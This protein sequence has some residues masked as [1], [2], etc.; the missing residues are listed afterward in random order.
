M[1]TSGATESNN[2]VLLGLASYGRRIGRTHILASSIEHTSVL[3]PL[4]VLG[5]ESFDIE[6]LPVGLDGYV[7]PAEVRSRLRSDTLLVSIMHANNETGVLQPVLEI[8]PLVADSKAFF[9]VDAAQTFG[10]EVQ[11]LRALE[12][13]FLSISGH[14]ILGPKGV[15]ALFVKRV[16][17]KRAML[18]PILHGGGQEWGLRPGTLPVPLIVG[19]GVAAELA[20]GEHIERAKQAVE[21]RR[22]FEC[23]LATVDHVVNGDVKRMQSHVLNVS[24]PGVD[25]EALMLALRESMAISNGAA[26]SSA[27]YRQSHVLTAMGFGPDRISSSVRFS[28]GPGVDSIPFDRLVDAIRSLSGPTV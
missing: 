25:S 22:E 16:G 21:I 7:H 23:H 15:G 27:S 19:L 4:E 9:H 14:K 11:E 5:R 12:C 17:N 20:L 6:L 24:F 2:L 18:A 8:A 3:G 28:W 26:C 13:D 10:K 1:F